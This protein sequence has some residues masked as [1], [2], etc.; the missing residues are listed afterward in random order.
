LRQKSFEDLH[1]LW[2]LLLKERNV[3]ASQKEEARR[4]QVPFPNYDRVDKVNIFIWI[5]LNTLADDVFSAKS[6]WHA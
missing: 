4:F 1:K 3:L 2:F 6:Q 5:R